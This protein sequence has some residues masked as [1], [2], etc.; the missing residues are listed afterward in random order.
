MVHSVVALDTNLAVLLAVG[1]TDPDH[2]ARHKRLRIYDKAAFHLLD[3]LLGAADSLVW[4]PHVLAETSNLARY[5]NDPIRTEV[6]RTLALLIEKHRECEVTSAD[7]AS[8]PAYVRLGLTDSVLLK[9]AETGATL[10]TDDLDLHLAA[11]R[12]GHASINFNELRD[13]ALQ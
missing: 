2:I 8:H 5:I 7:A 12:S 11:I 1:A 6:S 3:A 4:C 13:Q 10:V 9:L